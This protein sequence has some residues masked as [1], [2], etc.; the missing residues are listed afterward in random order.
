MMC[1][2]TIGANNR[3]GVAAGDKFHGK[4]SLAGYP[5]CLG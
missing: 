2:T 3:I 1:I 4:H 5:L